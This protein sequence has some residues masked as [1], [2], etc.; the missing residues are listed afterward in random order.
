[1]NKKKEAEQAAAEVALSFL[2][3]PQTNGFHNLT[4]SQTANGKGFS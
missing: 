1:V 4:P 3:N 2:T